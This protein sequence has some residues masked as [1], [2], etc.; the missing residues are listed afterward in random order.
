MTIGE[1]AQPLTDDTLR[2]ARRDV[3][4][5]HARDLVRTAPFRPAYSAVVMAALSLP[6][7][8]LSDASGARW[9]HIVFTC[10]SA[11]GGRWQEAVPLAAAVELFMTALDLLDDIEDGEKN[12][13]QR[14]LGPA[15][16][17]NA[18]TGLLFLAHRGVL[19]AL[20]S[21]ALRILLDAGLQ[22]SGGQDADLTMSGAGRSMNLDASVQ[23]SADKSAA[24]V[25][26]ICRLGALSA[27]AD[28]DVQGLYARFGWH[29][30]LVKQLANDIAGSHQSAAG[31]T[32][33]AL[34]RPTL[35]LTYATLYAPAPEPEAAPDRTTGE[36][37]YLTWAVADA[38]RRRAL[39]LVPDLTLDGEART[40]LS[41]L[42]DIL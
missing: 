12:E 16:A 11:V 17:L 4:S 21:A 1:G 10:C 26:A 14:C 23:T 27:G 39:A 2:V 42:L 35:P 13:V 37:L 9:A 38:Y 19:D 18:S 30:G 33:R 5:A 34:G 22:A 24:L 40:T 31:K 29:L 32:D 20:G 8:V 41:A 7:A 15:R 36:A 3:V 6:G 25:A 28:D